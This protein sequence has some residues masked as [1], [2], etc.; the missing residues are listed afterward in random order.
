VSRLRSGYHKL[1]P[2]QRQKLNWRINYPNLFLPNHS[3][4]QLNR[5]VHTN[6]HI[7]THLTKQA[8]THK[9][10]HYYL[11]TTSAHLNPIS[12]PNKYRLRLH[13]P[14]L[15]KDQH[16]TTCYWVKSS[17]DTTAG[18]THAWFDKCSMRCLRGCQLKYILITDKTD[19][20]SACIKEKPNN[21]THASLSPPDSRFSCMRQSVSV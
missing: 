3:Q 18:H 5:H 9:Y 12:D 19:A 2:P 11:P 8:R 14:P 13:R 7:I 15:L 1:P 21:C 10:T 6:T 20:P 16:T 4:P 17:S